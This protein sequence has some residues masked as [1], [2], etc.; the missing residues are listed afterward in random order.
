MNRTKIGLQA[1]LV[2]FK[3]ILSNFIKDTYMPNSCMSR[4]SIYITEYD[5]NNPYARFDGACNNLKNPSKGM[6]YS[7]HRRLL[8]ADY[9]DGISTLRASFVNHCQTR[10]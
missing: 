6:T 4:K 7:C 8:A 9:E 3:D 2:H 1:P 5:L 10:E